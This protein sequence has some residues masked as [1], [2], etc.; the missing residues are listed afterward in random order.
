M[1]KEA[2][3]EDQKHKSVFQLGPD[4]NETITNLA[5]TTGTTKTHIVRAAVNLYKEA[6]HQSHNNKGEV[7]FRDQDGTYTKILIP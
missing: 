6:Y 2:G 7:L 5:T 4:T 1:E 3:M